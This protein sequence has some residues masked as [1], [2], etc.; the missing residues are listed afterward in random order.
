MTMII[1]IIFMELDEKKITNI[2]VCGPVVYDHAH[3]GHAR[4]Y[5]MVDLMRRIM[6]NIFNE[7][8]RLV[9]NIVDIDDKIIRRADENNQSWPNVARFYEKSFFASMSKLNIKLPNTIIRVSEIIP[10]IVQYIQQIIY[11]G[12]AYITNDGSVYFDTNSYIGQGYEYD[13]RMDDDEEHS[14]GLE[15]RSKYKKDKRD[16]VLWKGCSI[17]EVGFDVV[18]ICYGQ[19]I[20]SYGCPSRNVE[21]STIIHETIGTNLDIHFGDSNLKFSH[22]YKEQLQAHAYYHPKYK[23][24]K[25]IPQADKKWCPN[26][27]HIGYLGMAKNENNILVPQKMSKSPKNFTIDGVLEDITPNQMRWIFM[28]HKWMDPMNF[29]DKTILDAKKFDFIISNFFNRIINYPF[30]QLIKYDD[31]ESQLLSYFNSCFKNIYKELY[32]FNLHLVCHSLLSLINYTNGY[33]DQD[34]PQKEL[35]N[36]IYQE[37]VNFTKILGFT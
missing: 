31:K 5:I 25:N 13:T 19:N 11:N 6:K 36:K 22:H 24:L 2:Y 8:I 34:N 9:M 20:K 7:K 17:T 26:F 28:H 16:F 27:M 10:K 1:I 37:I 4:I 18:F 35:V 12:F 14:K 32:N 3:L 21:C 23:P 15:E 30:S 33:L 29:S